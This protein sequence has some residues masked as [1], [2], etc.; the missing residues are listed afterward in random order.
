[1][2]TRS[3]GGVSA[4]L[5]PGSAPNGAQTLHLAPPVSLLDVELLELLERDDDDE[6]DEDDSSQQQCAPAIKPSDISPPNP[7]TRIPTG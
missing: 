6:D 1:M 7:S 2:I 4:G 3:C 5:L